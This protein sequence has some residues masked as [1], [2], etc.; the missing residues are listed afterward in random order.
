MKLALG[1]SAWKAAPLLLVLSPSPVDV[2]AREEDNTHRFRKPFRKPQRQQQQPHNLEGP[3]AWD[4]LAHAI[5]GGCPYAIESEEEATARINDTSLP[6]NVVTVEHLR[7][8]RTGNHFTSVYQ[9]LALGYCC[10][11]KVVWLPPKD[12]ILAPGMFSEGADGPRWFDFS[13]APDM[14]GFDSRSCVADITWA[15]QRAFHMYQLESPDSEFHTP[16]LLEC[17]KK[18]PR[19][20]ECEAAYFFPRDY[21]VCRAGA[22]PSAFAD[23]EEGEAQSSLRRHKL[24]RQILSE[25]TPDNEEK[26]GQ[27]EPA[28]S[29]REVEGG[30]DGT[31]VLHVR[32]GDIFDDKVL[33]Y[34]GQPPLQF[35]MQV[36][37]DAKWDRVDVVTNGLDKDSLNPVIPALQAKLSAGELPAN[38]NI[39]TNRS[40]DED[41]RSMICADGLAMAR[42]TLN[43]LTG[44][45][46]RAKRIYGPTECKGQLNILA[47]HRPENEVIGLVWPGH[48]GVYT[49]W[50]NTSDQR[51]EMLAYDM[52]DGF[53]QCSCDWRGG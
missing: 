50:E 22:T 30:G 45:H 44:F 19:L 27:V 13:S 10:K 15:G 33:A 49:N 46:S 9:N 17:V 51:Q 18:V 53:G 47:V 38:V 4:N 28:R 3:V 36:M 8:C 24:D 25:G 7:F 32:S 2:L 37:Q 5:E 26:G 1:S 41:L 43:T 52:I 48:Y 42:S 35:Y 16:G 11:S 31:L 23:H 40:M 20:L 6:G 21:D 12:D 34:Y 29:G 39:H 14:P